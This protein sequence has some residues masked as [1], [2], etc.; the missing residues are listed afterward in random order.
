V[1]WGDG[2]LELSDI[3]GEIEIKSTSGDMIL[4][5]ISGPLVANSVSGNLTAEFNSIRQGK[6]TSIS[7]VSGD[8]DLTVPS[9][10][11]VDFKLQSI[12]GEI[13]TDLDLVSKN[14]DPEHRNLRQIG[15]GYTIQGANNGGGTEFILNTVSGNV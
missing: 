4:K 3:N 9:D 14:K 11:Q 1:N 2:N 10:S 15:G 5:N 13:Y 7:L 6:P 8:I 12:V